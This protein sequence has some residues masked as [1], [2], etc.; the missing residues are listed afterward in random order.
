MLCHLHVG[1]DRT[2][3]RRHHRA[4]K[5]RQ[6]CSRIAH[7]VQAQPRR[8]CISGLLDR[9]R[10]IGRGDM[11]G[12][13]RRWDIGCSK[14]RDCAIDFRR[15]RIHRI[16]EDHFLFHR[17]V[18]SSH[19]EDGAQDGGL[20]VLGGEVCPP[21]LVN[22]FVVSGRR[23]LNT[24]GPTEATVVATAAECVPGEPVTIGTALPGYMTYVL[25]EQMRAVKPGES[26]ELYIGGDSI[27]RG[28]MNQPELTAERF[29][30]NPLAEKG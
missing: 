22:R 29:L 9:V 17:T 1:F 6:L 26:G 20:L 4:S 3:K 10:C 15:C 12:V 5:R 19:D 16:T 7:C 2:T 25:D 28:Y 30:L 21:E 14:C 24:Y 8:S 13:L 11:G 18:L 23:M 27:A